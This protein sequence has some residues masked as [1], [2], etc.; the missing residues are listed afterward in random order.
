MTRW[1]MSRHP[2]SMIARVRRWWFGEARKMSATGTKETTGRRDQH[3]SLRKGSHPR[4]HKTGAP[5]MAAYNT[6]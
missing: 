3:P 4:W 6:A 1:D 5:R 2:G